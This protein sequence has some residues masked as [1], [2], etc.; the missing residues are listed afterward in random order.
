[1]KTLKVLDLFCCAGGAAV[2]YHRA[3]AAA[4]YAVDI[5]GVDTMPQKHYPFRFI[6]ADAMTFPLDGYDFIHAS[7]PCQDHS[8]ASAIHPG[9]THATGWMLAATYERFQQLRCPW[10]IENVNTAKMQ[11][12]VILC[13][14]MFALPL[15]R[16]R[17]FDSSHLLYP[18]G[19]CQHH[20]NEIGVYGHS[21]WQ[22]DKAPRTARRDGRK[23]AGTVSAD[24]G[25]T[26]MD[27]DWMTRD[28]LAQAIPPAY[29]QFLGS[30]IA[31][32]IAAEREC[33]A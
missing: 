30:Q 17:K 13:G 3:F 1:M 5:T 12:P 22:L 18:H 29:T 31:A 10:I 27:I 19:R 11:H 25:N 14:T 28:E 20:G 26:A 24:M 16:H 8:S 32:I 6:Q 23:R 4:G 15:I 33:V 21:V 7:P 2:G 9:L